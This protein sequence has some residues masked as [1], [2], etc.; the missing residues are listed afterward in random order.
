MQHQNPKLRIGLLVMPK[1]RLNLAV[2]IAIL[3]F[4]T[5]TLLISLSLIPNWRRDPVLF[6]DAISYYRP[7]V[8]LV[9]EG[10]FSR[11]NAPPYLWEPYRTPGYSILIAGCIW[12]FGDYRWIL[13]LAAFTAAWA[14]WCAVRLTELWGGDGFAQRAAGILVAVLPNSL[15][16]ATLLMTDAIVGHLFL[17][18]L[19]LFYRGFQNRLWLHLGGSILLILFLQLIKPTFAISAVMILGIGL[20]FSRNFKSW[21]IIIL[22]V[23]LTFPVPF[24]LAK[25]NERDHHVFSVSLLGVE[26]FREYLQARYLAKEQGIDY[27]SMV[28]TIREEDNAAAET[29]DSPPSFYGRRYHIKKKEVISFIQEHPLMMVYLMT[30]Q[31]IRQF[32]APQEFMIHAFIKDPPTI[33]RVGGSLLT[34]GFWLMAILA[35]WYPKCLNDRRIF[36]LTI[37]ILMFFLITA[38]ISYRVGARLR[39]PADMVNI[40]IVAIGLSC[41]YSKIISKRES[42]A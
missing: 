11:E 40:P 41:F 3:C 14:G 30:T 23:L 27:T 33:L 15:G 4:I 34:L 16:L 18:W 25:Q 6:S 12:I 36:F 38:S 21:L 5:H 32:A 28:K 39:F 8:N 42:S 17:V 37:G 35:F 29:L 24:Y 20:L 31:M 26:T 1:F 13:Y 2:K 19:Y 10:V 7:A 9:E 22:L